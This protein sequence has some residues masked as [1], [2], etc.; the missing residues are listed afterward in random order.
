MT[1]PPYAQPADLISRFDVRVVGDLAEDT[2]ARVTPPALLTDANV[3]AALNDGASM[4]NAA[5]QIGER[6]TQAQLAALTDA[7]QA[8]LFRL[9]CD[10]AFVFLC[11]RR[12]V[13]SPLYEECY[14]RSDEILT[15]LKDGALIFNVPGNVSEG[16]ET[17]NFPS[18]QAYQSVH[19]IRTATHWLFPTRRYQVPS[20]GSTS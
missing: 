19:T 1:T 3:I 12:G 4:I 15:R 2:G 14:K 13:K 11:Q 18:A 8:L 20:S 10:L 9:N 16:T 17:I 5:C 7:D 6:Y